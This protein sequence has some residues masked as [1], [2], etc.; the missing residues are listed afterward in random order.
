M[1]QIGKRETLA[2]TM[3]EAS[4]HAAHELAARLNMTATGWVGAPN[5]TDPVSLRRDTGWIGAPELEA[6]LQQ[7]KVTKANRTSS[8][9]AVEQFSQHSAEV[10]RPPETA[11]HLH[12]HQSGVAAMMS[13]L[14][15]LPEFSVFAPLEAA[16]DRIVEESASRCR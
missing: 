2:A 10:E 9:S 11:G 12:T 1:T 16:Y 3:Q 8:I 4:A 7:L 5:E 14:K 15:Q 6:N 13:S